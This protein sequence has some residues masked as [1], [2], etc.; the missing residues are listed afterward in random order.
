MDSFEDVDLG[1]SD[2]PSTTDEATNAQNPTNSLANDLHVRDS[3]ARPPKARRVRVPSEEA[4]NQAFLPLHTN[5]GTSYPCSQSDLDVHDTGTFQEPNKRPF[6]SPMVATRELMLHNHITRRVPPVELVAIDDLR[7]TVYM[8]E[9]RMDFGPDLA[10]KAFAD[11]DLIFFAGHLRNNVRV[12]WVRAS[13]HP[14]FAVSRGLWGATISLPERGKCLIILNA[15]LLLRQNHGEDPLRLI[16]GTLLHE[17]CHAC[18]IVR[19]GHG[20]VGKRR[21]H[22]EFFCTRIAVIHQRAVGDWERRV[23]QTVSFFPGGADEHGLGG[24]VG[25]GCDDGCR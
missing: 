10:V 19:C 9:K 2:H 18:Q 24:G 14:R 15:D 16:F 21:G 11:L 17:M 13:D 3:E 1:S 6:V 23:L 12:R 8:V 4:Y 7:D 20:E 25:G 5:S 22:D